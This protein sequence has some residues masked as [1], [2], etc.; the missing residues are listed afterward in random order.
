[1]Q[2]GGGY[3]AMLPEF[4]ELFATPAEAKTDDVEDANGNLVMPSRLQFEIAKV[5]ALVL[6]QQIFSDLRS[7]KIAAES[8]IRRLETLRD[9]LNENSDVSVFDKLAIGGGEYSQLGDDEPL[10]M[11]LDRAIQKLNKIYDL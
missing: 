10:R 1:M 9:G 7:G 4:D 11:L 2:K 3:A 6:T 8:A 5:D